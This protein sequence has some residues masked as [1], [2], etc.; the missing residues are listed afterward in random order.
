MSESIGS[1][2][3]SEAN[4]VCFKLRAAVISERMR[5]EKTADV[6]QWNAL[7]EF[8]RLSQELS[9]LLMQEAAME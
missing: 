3:H 9:D 4:R 6:V 7:D 5:V 1:E 8:V 2:R